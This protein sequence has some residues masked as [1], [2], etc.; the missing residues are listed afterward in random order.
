MVDQNDKR[1]KKHQRKFLLWVAVNEPVCGKLLHIFKCIGNTFYTNIVKGRFILTENNANAK[2]LSDESLEN[3]F[4]VIIK[5][6]KRSNK[7]CFR[8][9][10]CSM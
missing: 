2:S 4:S 3:N 5:Q 9:R 8:I 7:I 1:K 10:L 6:Q